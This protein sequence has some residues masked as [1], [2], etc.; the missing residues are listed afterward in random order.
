MVD[1]FKEYFGITRKEL[2][3]RLEHVVFVQDPVAT[4]TKLRINKSFFVE[5]SV[6]ASRPIW[7][8]VVVSGESESSDII[9]KVLAPGIENLT[10]GYPTENKAICLAKV[11]DFEGYDNVYGGVRQVEVLDVVPLKN[12]I[13]AVGHSG[14][15]RSLSSIKKALSSTSNL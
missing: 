4:L 14:T 2:V 12:P 11:V 1:R 7:V 6:D 13:S 15:T 10:G 3:A 8:L 9:K 5:N